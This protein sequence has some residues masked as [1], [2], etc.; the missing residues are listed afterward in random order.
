[1]ERIT[2]SELEVNLDQISCYKWGNWDTESLN[3]LP[4]VTQWNLG[5]AGSSDSRHSTHSTMLS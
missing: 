2:E 1:M 5:W 3:G 4:E